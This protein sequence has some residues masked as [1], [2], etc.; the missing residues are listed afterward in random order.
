MVTFLGLNVFG[1]VLIV[2]GRNR[3]SPATSLMFWSGVGMIAMPLL[4]IGLFSLLEILPMFG[5]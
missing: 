4:Y 5:R 2:A 1:V 3:G